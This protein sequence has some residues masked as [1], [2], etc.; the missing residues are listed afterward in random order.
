MPIQKLRAAH[1]V[2]LFARLAREGGVGG[3]PLASG[4]VRYAH[5]VLKR[6]LGHAVTWNVIG[7]NVATLAKPPAVQKD[8]E[9]VILTQDQISTLLRY[10]DGQP[11][12]TIISF[13]LGTGCRRGEALALRWADINLDK[14]IIR[15]ERSVEQTKAGLRIKA[16]KTKAGKRNIAISPFLVTELR[17][18][19]TRQNTLR[20]ALGLGRGPDAGTV[21]AQATGEVEVPQRITHAFL[22]ATKKLGLCCRLHDLRHFHV[23]RL[24]A[25]GLDIL[26]I[27]RRIGHAKPSITLDVYGHLL[28][29]A[30][31]RAAEIM[32]AALA[33][34][35]GAP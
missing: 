16:P 27:S 10:L 1:L 35:H 25:D 24:V 14:G 19:R 11:L 31:A 34:V 23:S 8:D 28:G 5:A 20:L 9:I 18:H 26:T 13:L 7:T 32:E 2:E 30:D 4:S 12:R 3:R 29:G 21:F 22:R 15:I 33:G 6:L 17:A